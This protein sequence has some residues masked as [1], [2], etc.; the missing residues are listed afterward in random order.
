MRDKFKIVSGIEC[1]ICTSSTDLHHS[2]IAPWITELANQSITM[3]FYYSCRNCGFAYFE[4]FP[5]QIINSLYAHYRSQQYFSF[6][7]SW[8]PW[9]GK[10]EN[11]AFNKE[12]KKSN[13]NIEKRRSDID[14]VFKKCGLSLRDIDGCLDFGGDRG[15]FIPSE[16]QGRKYIVDPSITSSYS[17]N[18]ILFRPSLE[19]IESRSLGLVMS[20]MT[21]EHVNDINQVLES[22]IKVL[23][24]LGYIY[25]EV[26]MDKFQVSKHCKST[27]YRNYL[28]YISRKKILFCFIDFL[29]G[30]WRSVFS[31]IPF[32]GIIKQSEHIN[33]FD[34]GTLSALV[35][36]FNLEPIVFFENPSE[37]QGKLRFG[38]ISFLCK[39]QNTRS[40][41]TLP[42]RLPN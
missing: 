20:C 41:S 12:G 34:V 33:Y 11:D 14:A 38:K 16:V 40:C 27:L 24:P 23:H 35:A 26:P 18:G 32:W 19:E 9:F 28:T 5:E 39:F 3:S 36:Q 37:R 22:I 30:V 8:E 1:F 7:H 15:Q 31:R 25:L 13:E 29:T 2:V 21:L 4:R 17:A 42:S 6:R 10:R